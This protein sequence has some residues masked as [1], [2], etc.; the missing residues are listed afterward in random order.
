MVVLAFLG[1]RYWRSTA[2]FA[3]RVR[4]SHAER[5]L[6]SYRVSTDRTA[7]LRRDEAPSD[8]GPEPEPAEPTPVP[9]DSVPDPEVVDPSS[10]PPEL[11]G[12]GASGDDILDSSPEEL[13]DHT[14]DPTGHRQAG[15]GVVGEPVS[16]AGGT[17]NE[18]P[19]ELRLIDELEPHH[20]R[21]APDSDRPVSELLGELDAEIA[22]LPSSVEM[23]DL[24]TIE[25]RRIADRRQEL[26]N[27]RAQ[28]L[29]RR[30]GSHRKRPRRNSRSSDE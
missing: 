4:E 28:L 19:P 8:T 18:P 15:E 6:E 27:Q 2:T 25:R 20:P 21:A 22:A 16:L 12:D 7:A 26:M 29:T 5:A 10:S 1:Y 24:P 23:M 14:A 30:R 11:D 9:V 3:R 17:D 13:D